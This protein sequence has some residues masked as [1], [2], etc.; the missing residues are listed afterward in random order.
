MR[1]FRSKRVGQDDRAQDL[2]DVLFVDRRR[3]ED[4]REVEL[5]H[6]RLIDGS[7]ELVAVQAFE[8]HVRDAPTH[9]R[10]KDAAYGVVACHV[11]S[12]LV[13]RDQ[14][15]D[16]VRIDRR[17]EFVVDPGARL[18]KE[19]AHVVSHAG[20]EGV[21]PDLG[22]L[23][24]AA[25]DLDALVGRA[26][27]QVD[28]AAIGGEI[29]EFFLRRLQ[30]FVVLVPEA[31]VGR[32]VGHVAAAPEFGDVNLALR[33]GLEDEKG[34]ELRRIHDRFDVGE[35][36]AILL[37]EVLDPFLAL[38]AGEF[39]D[40][41]IGHRFRLTGAGFGAGARCVACAGGRG[42]FRGRGWGIAGL[43]CGVDHSGQVQRG[44]Q[45]DI[46]RQLLHDGTSGYEGQ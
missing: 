44:N 33:I 17:E 37:R 13:L 6:L 39:A 4:L 10:A 24:E 28:A 16:G 18:E 41:Q 34:V 25:V 42:R 9:D 20:D 43:W 1:E 14:L 35:E 19:K 40:A 38:A 29:R 7:Q 5:V 30:P 11:R 32:A 23:Q 45:H 27:D 12:D 15:L 26:V 8:L 46:Q 31:V 3:L 22:R 36:L 2:V 21:L